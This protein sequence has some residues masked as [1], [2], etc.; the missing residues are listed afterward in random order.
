MKLVCSVTLTALPTKHQNFLASLLEKRNP[1]LFK[2]VKMNQRNLH[3]RRDL[4]VRLPCQVCSIK[5]RPSKVTL[6]FRIRKQILHNQK[7]KRQ[8]V[9]LYLMSLNHSLE[10]KQPIQLPAKTPHKQRNRNQAQK[11]RPALDY[12]RNQTP[13]SVKR[14]Q[15]TQQKL[16]CRNQRP[17]KTIALLYLE[18][19][20]HCLGN[21]QVHRKKKRHPHPR[22]R[23]K[24]LRYLRKHQ[25]LKRTQPKILPYLK[26]VTQHPSQKLPLNQKVYHNRKAFLY[27]E[28]SKRNCFQIQRKHHNQKQNQKWCQQTSQKK[29]IHYS[30]LM[31]KLYFRNRNQKPRKKKHPSWYRK[32]SPKWNQNQS[33]NEGWG[34]LT[35][36]MMT[37]L[38]Q[39]PPRKQQQ[40]LIHCL[41]LVPV[42]QQLQQP[43]RKVQPA[44]LARILLIHYFLRQQRNQKRSLSLSKKRPQHPLC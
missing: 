43:S 1:L 8:P 24:V 32:Q 16:K 6:I 12:S 28:R 38:G 44:Y 15:R 37:C 35:H 7:Q 22:K 13:C 27:L 19:L 40:N 42:H 4:L 20:I 31:M 39:A 41:T 33:Q 17:K 25:F 18:N 23:Q 34:C 2:K 14:N 11:K 29:Q 26:R 3:P 30:R 21:H 9:L 10:S 36:P 5:S